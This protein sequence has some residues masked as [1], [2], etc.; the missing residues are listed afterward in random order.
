MCWIDVYLSLLDWIVT[1][2]GLNFHATEFKKAA[3]T[4]SISIKEV[5]IEAHHSISKVE[6][7][8]AA[9][10]RAYKIIRKEI[11]VEPESPPSAT[12]LQRAEAIKKAMEAV[13][14][15]HAKKQV[16]NALAT[17]N[18]PDITKKDGWQGPFRLIANDGLTCT[19]ELPHGPRNFRITVV[20]PYYERYDNG[21]DL[22]IQEG[23]DISERPRGH[24]RKR[25][26][27]TF[28]TQ[29]RQDAFV[30]TKE[31]VDYALAVELRKRG[32]ITT[33]GEPFEES[34]KAEIKAL[35]E[36]GVFYIVTYNKE[37][38]SKEQ[39]FK[40]Q[41]VLIQGYAD[42]QKKTI[43]TQSPT[44]QRIAQR[45]LLSLAPTLVKQ[46]G[47]VVWLRD[48]TQAYTQ[49]TTPLNH[50]ILTQLPTQI[51]HLYP[52]NS[53]IIVI[54][55]LYG[56]AEAEKLQIDTSTFNPCLLISSP[57]TENFGLIGMQTDDTIGLTNKRFSD[58]EDNKGVLSLNDNGELTLQ[59]KGQGK[60][61]QPVETS[62][63]TSQQ[64][65]V[66]QR[67]RRAYI[68]SIYQPE[69]P[70][71]S[72]IKNLNRRINWQI[73]NPNRGQR[74]QPIKLATAKL[75]VFVNSSFTN[76]EDLTSQL[77]FIIILS[78]KQLHKE[79]D[80]SNGNAFTLRGN[81]IHYSSTKCKRV[82]QS[83]LASKIYSILST[84]KEKRLIIDIIAL[85]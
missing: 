49:S 40:S 4:L 51:T 61:L 78:N 37:R 48:I 36:R 18:G 44:I 2:V 53:I 38:H 31:K 16:K 6:R 83:V 75:F 12:T 52:K 81:I 24:P 29:H 13:R 50:T 72:E 11:G 55:P 43:L 56:I 25:P 41:I 14:Q 5:P 7:Y 9:L 66:K 42:N 80:K 28:F 59:Q 54:K 17:R 19:V 62:S 34:N 45:L 76:N 1:D 47:Y 30:T 23:E 3:R 79:N 20:K 77:R 26:L 8:Y 63:S 27:N 32:V 39:I 67:A 70:S 84:T 33:P 82:I 57:N 35:I 60:K 69:A 21:L 74:F 10:C 64:Q 73:K 85:Q 46:R 71:E 65:Y 58:Q 68:T 22:R 15:I